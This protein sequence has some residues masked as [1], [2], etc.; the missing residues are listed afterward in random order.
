MRQA[1][2]IP[3]QWI[4]QQTDKATNQAWLKTPAEG[5]SC[6]HNGRQPDSK[7]RLTDWLNDQAAHLTNQPA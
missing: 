6:R 1:G 3:V 4:G 2:V 5:Q 7:T